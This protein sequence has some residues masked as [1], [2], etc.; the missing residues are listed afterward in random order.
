MGIQLIWGENGKLSFQN[1]EE[2]YEALGVLARN[3]LTKISWKR[4][5]SCRAWGTEGQILCAFTPQRTCRMLETATQQSKIFCNDFVQ[6]L[7]QRHWFQ[8]STI[9]SV[10][11]VLVVPK[12]KAGVL[13]TVP[14]QY[15]YD[16]ERGY[17]R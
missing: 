2:Y 14:R 13:R 16:F 17:H 4:D 9:P 5:E 15:W 12:D 7:I 6:N 11:T 10:K 3:E 1:E 8:E